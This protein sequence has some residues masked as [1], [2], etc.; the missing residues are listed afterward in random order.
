MAHFRHGEGLLNGIRVLDFSRHLPGPFATRRL[1]EMGAE[2]VKVEQPD[3]DPGRHLGPRVGEVGA[4]FATSHIGKKSICLDLRREA[5]RDVAFRLAAVADVVVESFLPGK[6]AEWGLD[7]AAVRAVN[8]GVVYCSLTGY[9]QTGAWADRPGHDLNFL[10]ASG[11]L[12]ALA[13]PDAPPAVPGLPLADLIGGMAA[14]EAI[15][16]ALVRRARTGEGAHLD[17]AVTDQLIGLMALPILL[18]HSG[19]PETLTRFLRGTVCYNV[20]AT[21][22]GRHVALAALEAK[23]WRAFCE[24]VGRPEWLPHQF[25]PAADDHAVYRAVAELFAARTR[26]EWAAFA[27]EVDCC[28]TPVYSPEEALASAHATSRRLAAHIIPKGKASVCEG[29]AER[30]GG[31]MRIPLTAAGRL[32]EGWGAESGRW[33]DLNEHADAVLKTWLAPENGPESSP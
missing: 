12:A 8:P 14:A 29:K 18:A 20:Y 2:V 32:A 21:R 30:E 27:R 17:I 19:T 16:A 5:D 33:P 10:A 13:G 15:V 6:M 1:A 31:E 26:D 23:F 28:L 11:M 24:A 25:A 9:G 7:Y 3:G 22:D 4:L